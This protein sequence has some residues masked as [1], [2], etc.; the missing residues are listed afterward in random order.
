MTSARV[1][2]YLNKVCFQEGAEVKNGDL[3]FEI[4][5]RPFQ[6]QY[7]QATSQI[8]LCEADLKFRKA[9]LER[10]NLLLKQNAISQSDFDQSVAAHDKAAAALSTAEASAEEARLNLDFTK[11]FS[12][13]DGEISRALIT[14][15]NLVTADQTL[16]TTVVSV[17]PMYV[18]FDID[19][20][21]ILR[22]QQGIR[23][24]A[25]KM[26]EKDKVPV[27]MGLANEEG[28]SH[29]G[30]LDFIEN[31][32]D[33]DTGTI[34]VRGVFPNPRPAVGPRVLT[35]GLFTRVRVVV[36]QPYEAILTAER[37]LGTDQGQ[38][39]LYV[40]NDKNV[41]EY[42]PVTVGNLEGQLRVIQTGLKPGERVVVNGLQRVRPDVKVIP[43]VVGIES[44]ADPAGGETRPAE[45]AGSPV[46]SGAATQQ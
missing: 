31:R 28:R 42:R 39:Y 7:D 12:P 21:T 41:V 1:T 27:W 33:P 34:Q 23:E 15:G 22:I 38:K 26:R 32:V 6:A 45:P 29:E 14:Q 16:L 37:A 35:P 17:D 9:D 8:K 30:Y 20:P 24:G 13:I 11:L 10:V 5:P 3:L 2:G 43:T 46:S 44:P 40:V 25:I 19:E 18:Y 4:D 36:G